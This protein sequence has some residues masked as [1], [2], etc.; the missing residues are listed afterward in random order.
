MNGIAKATET[1]DIQDT[2]LLSQSVFPLPSSYPS[3]VCPVMGKKAT[4]I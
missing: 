1:E 3:W 2:I 4:S